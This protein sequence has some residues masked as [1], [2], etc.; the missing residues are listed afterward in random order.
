MDTEVVKAF[1]AELTS[2]YESKP[3][4]SKKKI[5]DISKAAL[6]AKGYY[7]HVVFSVEK[8]LAK[9]SASGSVVLR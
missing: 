4:L 2:V 8:F 5:Q 3:P 7:K 1:N 6:K 9:V